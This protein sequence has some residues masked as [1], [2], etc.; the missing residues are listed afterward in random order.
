MVG[1]DQEYS[2]EIARIALRWDFG[3]EICGKERVR[4][5][6]DHRFEDDEQCV[7]HICI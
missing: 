7:L 6:E 4:G 1:I 2:D 3:Y 5:T